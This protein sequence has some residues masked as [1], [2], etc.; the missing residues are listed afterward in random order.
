[1]Q[2]TKL[3]LKQKQAEGI[4][5]A[6]SG[7]RGPVGVGRAGGEVGRLRGEVQAGPFP[8][9]GIDRWGHAR[10]IISYGITFIPPPAGPSREVSGAP[11]WLLQCA[12]PSAC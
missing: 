5:E 4:A 2:V 11:A 10:V 3:K 12:P 6:R 7:Q 1:M 9:A 8:P